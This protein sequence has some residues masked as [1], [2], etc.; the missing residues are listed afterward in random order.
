MKDAS[1]R[2]G[3]L[4]EQILEVASEELEFNFAFI[5]TTP[6]AQFLLNPRR[7]RGSDFLMRWS[8]GQWS[9]RRLIEAVNET[10]EFFA[11]PYGIS[12]VAPENDVK[13]AELY[14]EFLDK[15]NADRAKRPDILIFP[16]SRRK[17]VSEILAEVSSIPAPAAIETLEDKEAALSFFKELTATQRLPFFNETSALIRKLLQMSILG[18]EAENSLW[19]T[20]KMPHYRE[21]LRPMKRL[22]GKPGLPKNAVV[23][24]II[25]KEEDIEPLL[26]WEQKN[27]IPI[28]I[29]HV[30]YDR[31]FGI[32]LDKA[33][34][35]IQGG[36]IEPH[37][38]TF[39][40][41]G[42]ATTNKNTYRIYYHYAYPLAE[43]IGSP[44]LVADYILDKNGHI[45]P[46]VRFKGGKLRL[47][48]EAINIIK[49]IE[50]RR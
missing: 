12:S 17:E 36:L 47:T 23:P 14:F 49:D 19:V 20:E 32:S 28:H 21:P 25:L 10:G 15:A 45:L 27:E 34:A 8:Q 37:E 5:P 30:F 48:D 35:L 1:K 44:E 2:H 22:G 7:L 50:K 18:V 29:W 3:A 13:R 31:A 6:W 4:F 42:G 9:E 39:Q 11:L 26:A 41:P 38:Q 24:T 33:L 43:T 16:S 46:Y 40:S